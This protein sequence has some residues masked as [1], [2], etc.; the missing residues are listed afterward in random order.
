MANRCC[1]HSRSCSSWGGG[2]ISVDVTVS[3]AI[4]ELLAGFVAIN[5]RY[6]ADIALRALFVVVPLVRRI[7]VRAFVG[8]HCSEPTRFV[9]ALMNARLTFATAVA[10][11]G[12]T[13]ASSRAGSFR[14]SSPRSS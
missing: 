4:P 10:T 14:S 12:L 13:A 11:F 1:W 5:A 9:T 8:R 3:V 7:G 2:V 6:V